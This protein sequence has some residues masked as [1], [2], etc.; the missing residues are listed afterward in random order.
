[1][2]DQDPGATV[3]VNVLTS[4]DQI[5]PEDWDACGC[6]ETADGGRPFDPFTTWRFLHALEESGSVGRGTGWEP[7]YLAAELGGEVIAVAPLYAKGHSQGEYIFDHS[8][9]HAYERA[10]GDYYP[11][12]QVAV[13]FTPVTGRRFLTKPGHEGTGLAALVQ[14]AVQFGA[15]NELSSLHVTFCT[16]AEAIA[17]ERMGL[18]RRVTQQFHWE[19]RGY[20]DFDEFLA[21][22]SSRKRKNIRKERRTAQD[23][24]GTIRTLTGDEITA[25]HWDSFWHFYQDTGAR[26]WGT[27][28]LTRAFF[29]IA[30]ETLRDDIALVICE[31]DGMD[32]AGAL[33]FIGR[34]ALYGRYWGCV[35]DH[36]CLHFEACYYQAIDYA[37]AHGLD[38]VEAGAQGE[39]KLARG[40]LPAET[41]SLHWMADRGFSEAVARYLEEERQAMG[42]EIEILTAYGP[43]RKEER[44]EQQ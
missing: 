21:G 16:E 32:V 29:E 42:E 17:G 19:N 40:Y 38:R 8:W 3:A 27:P 25:E 28:Y 35:E 11:K 7:R 9:A 43:F 20:A 15:E 5:A 37:I 31:R 26:K 12:L 18:L 39:H 4:L 44:E 13:P 1:M 36:P 30:H 33:N 24:G 2:T 6:P 10:G 34:D 23:F 14:G 22:L 41:H